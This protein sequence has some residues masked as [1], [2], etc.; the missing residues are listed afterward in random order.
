MLQHTVYSCGNFLA[1]TC[2]SGSI[3]TFIRIPRGVVMGIP[4]TVSQ[5]EAITC[6]EF[7][8]NNS[9]TSAGLKRLCQG[10]N[11]IDNITPSC[12]LFDETAQIGP[13]NRNVGVRSFYYDKTCLTGEFQFKHTF[14][15]NTNSCEPIL[16][17]SPPYLMFLHDFC[18]SKVLAA[19]I[20]RRLL[21]IGRKF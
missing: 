6:A 15:A 18:T 3:T 17:T 19:S 21:F 7:C 16:G 8:R 10:F 11:Y 12:E 9:E 13:I 4:T 2:P 5:L 1:T 20:T 14:A